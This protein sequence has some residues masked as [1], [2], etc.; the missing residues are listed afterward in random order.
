MVAMTPRLLPGRNT[1]PAF[2]RD[3]GYLLL[4]PL[5]CHTPL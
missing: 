3:P 1:W 2:D 4:A 5:F